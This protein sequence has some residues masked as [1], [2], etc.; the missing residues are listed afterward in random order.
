M[1][2]LDQLVAASLADVD[3]DADTDDENDPSLLGELNMLAGDSE[4]ESGKAI[5][6]KPPVADSR[7]QETFLPTSDGDIKTILKTR[8]EQYQAAESKATAAG[9]TGKARRFQ[10]S[11]KTIQDLIKRANTGGKI[12]N[13]DIPPEIKITPAAPP[14]TASP[15][16]EPT[17]AAPPVPE[18][19]QKQ[20][21]KEIPD[22]PSTPQ[23]PALI[24]LEKSKEEYKRAAVQ[25]KN[26]GDK[27]NALNLI[28]IL[29]MIDSAIAALKAGEAIDLSDMPPPPEVYLEML[30]A[31][32]AEEVPQEQPKPVEPTPTPA[33]EPAA[34]LVMATTIDGALQQRLEVFQK[35]V[36]AAKAEGNGSKARRVG[37]IVKQYE[38]ALKMYK[39]GKL[40]NF[41]ELPKPEGFGPLPSAS[42]APAVPPRA[43]PRESPSTSSSPDEESKPE[44]PS[45]KPA[46]AAK[47]PAQA[48]RTSG[49][50]ANTTLMQTQINDLL[51]RQSEFR[52]AAIAAKKN[53]DLE[54]AKEYLRLSKGFDT[55]LD[56]ARGGLPV[57]MSSLPISPGERSKLEDSFEKVTGDD[58]P[59]G[60]EDDD[61]A[62][63]LVDRL[64]EQLKKQLNMCKETRDHHRAMGDVPGT[65]KFENLALSV[66]K[67]IDVMKYVKR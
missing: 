19:I 64:M 36:E 1:E 58:I 37:R 43:P 13:D 34:P 30:R 5:S 35:S 33:A 32:A 29:K 54:E 40:V 48:N 2:D 53:G 16:I 22:A 39:A 57:D 12:N 18:R 20:E 51:K 15:V 47:P 41:D 4:D 28:K 67:D 24:A 31:N 66:Q 8:L 42:A 49:N 44:L 45:P 52:A 7:P 6:T 9:D 61:D 65:N 3:T 27:P 17:R 21:P 26:A 55:V 38:D 60:E 23:S 63:G 59:N 14:Q 25:L 10:R 50:L 46:S 62:D 56:A 11:L